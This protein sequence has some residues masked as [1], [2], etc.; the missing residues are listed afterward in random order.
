VINEEADLSESLN[1]IVSDNG[2]GVIKITPAHIGLLGKETLQKSNPKVFIVEN[3][4]NRVV[5]SFIK[6]VSSSCRWFNEERFRHLSFTFLDKNPSM[7]P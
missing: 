6:I 2:V 1:Q 4:F 5:W 7:K 3:S